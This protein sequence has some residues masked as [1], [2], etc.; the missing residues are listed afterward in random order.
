MAIYRVLSP[1]NVGGKRYKVGSNIELTDEQAKKARGA[2]I[3]VP[4]SILQSKKTKKIKE[5]TEQLPSQDDSEENLN[6]E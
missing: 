4:E 1:I 5:P 2:V 6:E 3:E